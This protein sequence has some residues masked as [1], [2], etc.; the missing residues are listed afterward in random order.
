[1]VYFARFIRLFPINF[2][3]EFRK[4]DIVFMLDTDNYKKAR[5]LEHSLDKQKMKC[6]NCLVNAYYYSAMLLVYIWTEV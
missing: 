4:I 5:T 1:M 6:K 2:R 3:S